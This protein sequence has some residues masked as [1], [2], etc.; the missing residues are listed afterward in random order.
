MAQLLLLGTNFVNFV[1]YNAWTGTEDR[2]EAVR[3]TEWDEPQA[4]IGSY[5]HKYAYPDWYRKHEAKGRVL[6]EAYDKRTGGRVGCLQLRGEYLYVAQGDEGFEAYDVANIANKGFRSVHHRAFPHSDTTP[7]STPRTPPA[8]RSRP[9]A[10]PPRSAQPAGFAERRGDEQAHE[11][12][13]HGAAFHP[14]YNYALITDSE[15]G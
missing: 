14:L 9:P 3:V 2:I 15:E 11:R 4:V 7:R 1:G 10:Q 12:D 6:Q 13:K 8:W 5:L